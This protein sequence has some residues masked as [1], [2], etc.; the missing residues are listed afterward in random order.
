M[1]WAD[2]GRSPN[3]DVRTRRALDKL[4]G[5]FENLF[6]EDSIIVDENG[7]AYVVP[8]NAQL[9]LANQVFGVH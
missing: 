5:P 8:D 2:I 1:G 9:I 6:Q 7:R 4:S 3:T